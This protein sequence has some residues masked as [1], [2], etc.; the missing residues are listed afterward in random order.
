MYSRRL[1]QPQ[2]NMQAI[3]K[4][5]R[6]MSVGSGNRQPLEPSRGQGLLVAA[7]GSCPQSCRGGLGRLLAT[8]DTLATARLLGRMQSVG[9]AALPPSGRGGQGTRSP[10]RMSGRTRRN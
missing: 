4:V 1:V 3:K 7:D 6:A 5:V 8:R 9:V 2:V 10:P